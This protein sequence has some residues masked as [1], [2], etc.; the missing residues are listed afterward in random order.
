MRWFSKK[1]SWLNFDKDRHLISTGETPKHFQGHCVHLPLLFPNSG[2]WY[3]NDPY[4]NPSLPQTPTIPVVDSWQFFESPREGWKIF[5]NKSKRCLLPSLSMLCFSTIILEG[6]L[7]DLF[8]QYCLAK[9]W[10][11]MISPFRFFLTLFPRLFGGFDTFDSVMLSDTSKTRLHDTKHG[12][13]SMCK[14]PCQDHVVVVAVG[15]WWQLQIKVFIY[16]NHYIEEFPSC[17]DSPTS[18]QSFVLK[19]DLQKWFCIQVCIRLKDVHMFLISSHL[20]KSLIPNK[21]ISQINSKHIHGAL[22]DDMPCLIQW[23]I[24]TQEAK[25]EAQKPNKFPPKTA[26]LFWDMQTCLGPKR[27]KRS[28]SEILPCQH[29]WNRMH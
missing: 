28:T 20:A 15:S 5:K 10:W 1:D 22:T 18:H 13:L 27:S 21:R 24:T 3:S 2:G 7:K 17:I 25:C 11:G 23:I 8:P 12:C 14:C 19:V 16:Y 29:N 26:P 4:L 6:F 9:M